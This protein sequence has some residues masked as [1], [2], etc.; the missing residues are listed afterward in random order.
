LM[1]FRDLYSLIRVPISASFSRFR[2]LFY[3][4]LR[5]GRSQFF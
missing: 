2:R 1:V 4:R 5:V 3:F